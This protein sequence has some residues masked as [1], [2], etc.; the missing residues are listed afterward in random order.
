MCETGPWPNDLP[1]SWWYD[2]LFDAVYA[3]LGDDDDVPPAAADGTDLALCR[4]LT[5]EL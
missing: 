3:A 2:R 1:P 5:E 4:C